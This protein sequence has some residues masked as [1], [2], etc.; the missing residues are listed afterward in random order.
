MLIKLIK[1]DLRSTARTF[2]PICIGLLVLAVAMIGCMVLIPTE[3]KNISDTASVSMMVAYIICTISIFV[4]SVLAFLI[5]LLRFRRCVMK[6]D[7][8]LMLTIPISPKWHIAS[9]LLCS[10]VWYIAAQA[11]K[12]IVT[13]IMM[14]ADKD[15]IFGVGSLLKTL[16]TGRDTDKFDLDNVVYV[17]VSFMN[18]LMLIIFVQLF[19]YMVFVIASMSNKNKGLL[20]VLI[21]IGGSVLL[22]WGYGMVFAVTLRFTKD[23]FYDY[24]TSS[25]RYVP[26]LI[27]YT[28]LAVVF[29]IITAFILDKKYNLQ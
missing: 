27:Y 29:Y 6:N 13:G 1:S 11:C 22:S 10:V 21:A 7:A 24:L 17:A 5:P 26:S 20:T 14:L 19:L 4:F 25:I 23:N 12:G 9:K 15:D 3:G 28:V 8:Y 18:S 2:V 16:F